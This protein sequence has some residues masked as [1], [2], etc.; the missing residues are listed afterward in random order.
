LLA[1]SPFRI[2]LLSLIIVR[3]I[4]HIRILIRVTHL[5]N[6]PS[7]KFGLL[8][9]VLSINVLIVSWLIDRRLVLVLVIFLKF[10][11]T[12]RNYRELWRLTKLLLI[13]R[14]SIATVGR[15]R[16][17]HGEVVLVVAGMPL[18]WN[19]VRPSWSGSITSVYILMC[20]RLIKNIFAITR[21]SGCAGV[22]VRVFLSHFN[23]VLVPTNPVLLVLRVFK[24][25]RI[26]FVLFII[27]Y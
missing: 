1:V 24:D 22:I 11:L 8:L 21:V 13:R 27:I 26:L 12:L 9:V 20:N 16:R 3:S 17:R 19:R 6:I 2:K 4:S 10:V 5:L 15:V 18:V 25:L 23:V 7:L 14:R